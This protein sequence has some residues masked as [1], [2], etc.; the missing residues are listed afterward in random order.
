MKTLPPER[1]RLPFALFITGLLLC[2]ISTILRYQAP[3]TVGRTLSTP[4][5]AVGFVLFLVAAGVAWSRRGEAV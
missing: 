1:R 3:G 5:V 4:L 2:S